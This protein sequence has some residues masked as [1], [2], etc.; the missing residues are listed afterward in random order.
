MDLTPINDLIA[1]QYVKNIAE[2]P[3]F[4]RYTPRKIQSILA[5]NLF[6]LMR[7]KRIYR[8]DIVFAAALVQKRLSEQDDYVYLQSDSTMENLNDAIEAIEQNN[9][10]RALHDLVNILNSN[11]SFIPL[12]KLYEH[13]KYRA[14]SIIYRSDG[15]DD[16]IITS[17]YIALLSDVLH[18]NDEL[19]CKNPFYNHT[20]EE[21]MEMLDLYLYHFSD[22]DPALESQ[23]GGDVLNFINTYDKRRTRK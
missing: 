3:F 2:D 5:Y 17:K 16:Y 23:L 18:T 14:I 15:I 13:F 10:C 7:H 20:D 8:D 1:A 19:E 21:R 22:I 11:E 12:T 6:V 9:Y 4:D